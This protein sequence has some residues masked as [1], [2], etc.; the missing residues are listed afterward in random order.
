VISQAVPSVLHPGLKEAELFPAPI[1]RSYE[2]A[3]SLQW[4]F[5]DLLNEAK[6]LLPERSSI[7]LSGSVSRLESVKDSDIDYVLIWDDFTDQR[8]LDSISVGGISPRREIARRSVSRVN[9]SLAENDLRPCE[10]FS[11][12]KPVSELV[13][14]ENLFSRYSILTLID[15]T[16]VAGDRDFYLESLDT[17]KSRLEEYA[18]GISADVQVIRTLIWYI[19]REG[20]IDQLHY[21]T[22]VNRFSRLI[23][24]FATIF[25]IHHLGI[26]ATRSTKTTWLR[27]RNLES[28]LSDDTLECLERLWIKSVELKEYRTQKPMLSDSGFIGTSQLIETWKKVLAISK[29]PLL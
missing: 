24:L 2:R 27:L 15:S 29:S 19:E 14:T 10:S 18:I 23:Q 1:K 8:S 13:S 7:C 9:L 20:W 6:V 4:R 17:I 3:L 12:E 21:G 28:H 16:F 25:S 22:S 26:E 11:C 5:V